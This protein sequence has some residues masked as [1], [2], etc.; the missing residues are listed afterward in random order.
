MESVGTSFYS[1]DEGSWQRYRLQHNIVDLFPDIPTLPDRRGLH[2][3]ATNKGRS[4][5]NYRQ[6]SAFEHPYLSSNNHCDRWL[7]LEIFLLLFPIKTILK[8]F[9]WNL[10]P[11]TKH[12]E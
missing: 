11:F 8:L 3:S 7:F 4:M 5:V 6:S 1:G 10:N 9:S 12:K 2:G